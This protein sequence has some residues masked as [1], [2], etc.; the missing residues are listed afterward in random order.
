MTNIKEGQGF[1]PSL[2]TDPHPEVVVQLTKTLASVQKLLRDIEKGQGALHALLYDTRGGQAI[3]DF[4]QA[5]GNL[6]T[7]LVKLQDQQGLLPALLN[8][9]KSK[10]V[11]TDL[12]QI[13][14]DFRQVTDDIADGRGTVGGF[15]KDPT[16]YEN[17]AALLEGARRSWILRTVIQSTVNKGQEGE[18]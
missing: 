3:A 6:N 12:A 5:V 4:A 8:D 2:L 14:Q 16:L 13:T 17:L 15:I 7:W 1:L 9:P 18:R 11:L 10:Q